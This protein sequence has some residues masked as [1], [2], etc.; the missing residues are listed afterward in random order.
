[1]IAAVLCASMCA[2]AAALGY[3]LGKMRERRR[4]RLRQGIELAA[5]SALDA[6]G[7]T[8]GIARKIEPDTEY[9]DRMRAYLEAP[10]FRKR[11]AP[12]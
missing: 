10:P 2:A 5:G 6:H 4:A 1:M 3:Y 11:S 12:E 7:H 9:R 8:L